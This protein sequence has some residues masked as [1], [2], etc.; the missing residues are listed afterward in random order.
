MKAFHLGLLLLIAG[1]QGFAQRICP[2]IPLPQQALNK[3]ETCTLNGRTLIIA[4]DA[5]FQ[6]QAIWL[7]QELQKRFNINTAV[8]MRG[9]VF[10]ITLQSNKA[11]TNPEGYT[12]SMSSTGITISASSP[13]GAFYGA[14]TLL[15]LAGAAKKNDNALV[16]DCWNIKDEPRYAWR[17]LMLDESRFFFGKEKVRSLLDWMAFYK[18]NRFHWH[19]TDMPGW[20]LEIKQYPLL[21][22]VGGIGNYHDSKAP[23]TWYSQEDI[24]EMVAYARQRGITIIPEIDMP[25]HAGA[26]NRAYPEFDGGGTPKYPSFTFNPGREGTY[27]Y[28]TNILRE[29]RSL[30]PSGLIHLGGDEVTFG[31][32]GW[33]TD[34]GIVRL[35]RDQHLN[36][37]KEVED[38]FIQRMADS[39]LAMNSKVMAWDEIAT[40]TLPPDKTIVCWWRQEKPEN[41]QMAL[42]K[43]YAVVLCPR[44]PFY[45]DF[46]QDSTHKI[47][48]RWKDGEMNELRT[49]YN[50]S[51]TQLPGIKEHS[52]RILGVQA[53]MWTETISNSQR[54]DFMLF[55]RLAA[56]AETAWIPA[57]SGDFNQFTSRLSSHL[58]LY[59]QN[60]LYYFDY[61]HPEKHT[62]T[63]KAVK[64]YID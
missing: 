18:L 51:A 30:F 23:A 12:L 22:T 9:K 31:N 26:A 24:K 4:R 27:S 49:V 63:G 53:C 61:F 38:Y 52:D 48:R 17:G 64:D 33:D 50:F 20:R 56:L 37:R 62:E 10:T 35:M 29:T 54:L 19:L 43:G 14:V 21:T 25:G 16:L 34:S 13:D 47:G 59:Q 60:G 44:L 2:V 58:K 40:A 8:G 57:G 39:V 45:F 28:L 46:V 42:H 1:L 3:K 32:K 5:I 15:Q 41:L 7:Q 55:P 36:N 6:S 11:L